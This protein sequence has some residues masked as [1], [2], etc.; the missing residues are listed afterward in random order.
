M[1]QDYYTWAGWTDPEPVRGF[2]NN[3]LLL[4]WALQHAN[5]AGNWLH[6]Q[7]R[8]CSEGELVDLS[9]AVLQTGLLATASLVTA[10]K[11]MYFLSTDHRFTHDQEAELSL[12]ISGTGYS[13]FKH[14]LFGG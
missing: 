12:L 4:Q 3:K 2:D 9:N 7:V 14:W 6:L 13:L 1:A 11:I 5:I 8:S 10:R